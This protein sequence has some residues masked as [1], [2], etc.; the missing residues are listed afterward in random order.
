MLL[1]FP[2]IYLLAFIASLREVYRGHHAGI[3]IFIIFGVSM[4]LTAM[5]VMFTNGLPF[6]IPPFQFF[7]EILVLLV[8]VLNIF[9]LKNRPRFHLIDYLLFFYLACN[10]MYAVLPIGEQGF[11]DRLIALKST[12]FYIVVYFAGRLLDPQ[13]VYISKYLSYII[14]LTIAAGVVLAKEVATNQHLQSTTG[15]AEYS[16]YFFNI[17]PSGSYDLSTTFESEGGY[18]RFASFFANPLEHAAAT[19]LAISAILAMYTTDRNNFQFKKVSVAALAASAL[20][21]IFALSR[22]P[23]AAYFLVIY[24]Y[25]LVTRHKLIVRAFHAAAICGMLYVAYLFSDFNDKRDGLIEVLMNTIDFSNPSSVGHIIEWVTAVNSIIDRPLGLGLG[26]SGRV[27]ATLG[28]NVGGENQFLIIGVQTGVIAMFVYMYVYFLFIRYG[29][30]GLK[31]LKGKEHQL[32]LLILLMKVGLLIP[33]LTSEVESSSYISYM[34]WFLSGLFVSV[35]MRP[36]D[37]HEIE[38]VEA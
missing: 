27:G 9:A 17:K 3:L 2:L 38:L 37:T 11:T 20:S 1:I 6:L 29:L 8:L 13:K 22:A 23:L 24:V 21:I 31:Y 30:K 32:C 18:K 4:Y 35:L 7:K 33:S 15:Y 28:E 10:I 16:Y 25:A 12:S 14:V 19:L 5:P 34:E 36:R 26:S